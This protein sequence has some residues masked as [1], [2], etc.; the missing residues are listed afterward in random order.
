VISRHHL[1]ANVVLRFLRNDDPKQSPAA[2]RL[3][4]KAKDGKA[5]LA[6]TAITVAE[7]FYVLARVYKHARPEAAA[8]LLPLCQ[9]EVLEVEQRH[10]V[11][12]ALHRVAKANVDFGDAYLAA[13]A[14]EH[15]E[16]IASFDNDLLSF[17]D[18][19][20]VVPA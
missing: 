17:P 7:I 4:A 20:T 11:L 13:T 19:V 3:F 1:D 2:A 8:L 9:S 15:R 18:V 12:D 5:E 10:R 16:P 14:A 6:I